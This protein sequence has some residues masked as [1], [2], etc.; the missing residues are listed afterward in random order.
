MLHPVGV[1]VRVDVAARGQ[2]IGTAV[3]EALGEVA[4]EHDVVGEPVVD[5]E[6]AVP[7]VRAA[8][9]QGRS[10]RLIGELAVGAVVTEVRVE[11]HQPRFDVEPV[12]DVEVDVREFGGLPV[13]R[14]RGVVVPHPRRERGSG[15]AVVIELVLERGS[16]GLQSRHVVR[17]AGVLVG[18]LLPV[19]A[20]EPMKASARLRGKPQLVRPAHRVGVVLVVL[21]RHLAAGE[22]RAAVGRVALAGEALLRAGA[23][24]WKERRVGG[25]EVLHVLRVLVLAP[26]GQRPVGAREHQVG[27][28]DVPVQARLRELGLNCRAA[29]GRSARRCGAPGSDPRPRR[30]RRSCADSRW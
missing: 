23:H 16:A 17:T 4:V 3:A 21:Q 11:V 6:L 30:R 26:R 7:L 2:G 13:V 24:R 19:Q 27:D 18:G 25:G 12:G 14:A 20:G 28:A 22:G 8:H 1:A 10:H 9:R 5:A 29:P 15:G